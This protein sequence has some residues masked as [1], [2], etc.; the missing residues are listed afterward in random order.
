MC[1][2]KYAML[3]SFKIFIAVSKHNP[4]FT[5]APPVNQSVT[6][7]GV[8]DKRYKQMVANKNFA[9]TSCHNRHLTFIAP[10]F[11]LFFFYHFYIHTYGICQESIGKAEKAME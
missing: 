8:T 1:P 4:I 2:P 5:T 11:E 7:G 3:S 10:T 6:F 9:E